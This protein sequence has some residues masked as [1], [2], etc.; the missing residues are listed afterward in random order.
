MRP[1]TLEFVKQRFTEYYQRQNLTVPS[2]LEQREW[3]F[4]F[5]DAAAEVR[6]RR[7]M[8]FTDPLELGAYVKNLVPAHVYYS[9]A[10]YQTPSAPTMNEKHWAG[11]DLIFD[12]DAD[13]I[14][15]GPYAMM[16]ARVKEETEKLLGMLTDELGFARNHI[17]LAFSGGRGYHIHITDIAVRGWGSQ[18]RREIVDYVCGIGLDPGVMLTPGGGETG[19]RRRYAETLLAHLSWLADLDPA[20]AAAY[21]AGLDGIGKRTAAEFLANLDVLS[22]K[23]PDGLLQNRVIRAITAAPD[24][25]ERLRGAGARADEPVTTDIKRLIRTPG[26]LHGGSGMRVVPLDIRDFADFDP[27]VDAVVFGDRDVRL[28]VKANFTTSLLGNTYTLKAGVQHVPEALAVFLCCRG[29]AEITGG[30]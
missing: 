14:V 6:M 15:R 26:S 11:A 24:F 20:E 4:V 21:L 2:S 12:L 17:R 13:H 22:R 16:L 30:A 8:A 29:M 5:F 18:E 28:D 7:H 19:W 27:L 9:T 25:E 1:A 23:K 10:Y 3:G